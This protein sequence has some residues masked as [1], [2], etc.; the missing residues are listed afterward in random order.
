MEKI[1]KMWISQER[2]ELFWCHKK[3]CFKIFEGPSFC[4]KCDVLLLTYVFEK[5]NGSNA[6]KWQKL[7]LNKLITDPEIYI[8]FEKGARGRV[9]NRYSKAKNKYLKSYDPKQESKYLKIF[10]QVDLN[11]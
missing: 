10:Q 1:T 9:S 4:E 5:F 7:N 8:F 6:L 3:T 11:G 2:K